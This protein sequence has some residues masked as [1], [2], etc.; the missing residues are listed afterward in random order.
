MKSDPVMDCTDPN[1]AFLATSLNSATL[2]FLQEEEE[3][4]SRREAQHILQT[5]ARI[6]CPTEIRDPDLWPTKSAEQVKLSPDMMSL[7]LSLSLP[8]HPHHLYY[9]M[10]ETKVPATVLFASR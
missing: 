4:R 9:K 5:A 7:P 3:E 1:L 2:F 10:E 8:V 6:C